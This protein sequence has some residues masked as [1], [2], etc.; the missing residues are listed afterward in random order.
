MPSYHP[1][2]NQTYPITCTPSL[3]IIMVLKQNYKF[4]RN[5]YIY[6]VKEFFSRYKISYQIN[7][8]I[9]IYDQS[10]QINLS[11]KKYDQSCRFLS[12]YFIS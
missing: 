6:K 5:L 1:I 9:K 7:L 3:L 8:Y 4:K 11:I 12:H 2:T 10:H